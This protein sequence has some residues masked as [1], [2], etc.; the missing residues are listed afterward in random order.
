MWVEGA[1]NCQPQNSDDGAAIEALSVSSVFWVYL[2]VLV[3]FGRSCS[4]ENCYCGR[5][6]FLEAPPPGC[7]VLW[8]VGMGAA[9]AP[10]AIHRG[11]LFIASIVVVD[12][13]QT[14]DGLPRG[15]WPSV[16]MPRQVGSTPQIQ[17]N[18]V[19]KKRAFIGS[20]TEDFGNHGESTIT[21]LP[22]RNKQCQKHH[23][24]DQTT[25][26]RMT[27]F[28]F[29]DE[30]A[31]A[32]WPWE[33]FHGNFLFRNKVVKFPLPRF[34]LRKKTKLSHLIRRHLVFLIV[35]LPLCF[36]H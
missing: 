26:N 19:Q 17:F 30:V 24:K 14:N 5:N 21:K 9:D 11:S 28:S 8:S 10:V 36:P 7:A 16:H 6:N 15:R 20:I 32:L 12:K 23:K 27:V 3:L 29:F 1:L 4:E 34:L 18:S 22:V 31:T 2:S 13:A 35:L 33:F 25:A